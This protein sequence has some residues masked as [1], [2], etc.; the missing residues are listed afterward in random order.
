MTLF[1]GESEDPGRLGW[2]PDDTAMR[3][4]PKSHGWSIIT[5]RPDLLNEVVFGSQ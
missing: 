3:L 5:D 4:W 1:V 2:D